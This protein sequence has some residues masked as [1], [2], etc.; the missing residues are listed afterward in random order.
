MALLQPGVVQSSSQQYR[1]MYAP[2]SLFPG[3]AT[4]EK[5]QPQP[6]TDNHSQGQLPVEGNQRA[7]NQHIQGTSVSAHHHTRGSRHEAPGCNRSTGRHHGPPDMQAMFLPGS[8]DRHR[9]GR[10]HNDP[11]FGSPSRRGP[12][13][14]SSTSSLRTSQGINTSG[15]GPIHTTHL[16]SPS[17]QTRD[18]ASHTSGASLRSRGK[19]MSDTACHGQQP[20]PAV[21]AAR[22]GSEVSSE[23]L[24]VNGQSSRGQE[25]CHSPG[26]L[27]KQPSHSRAVLQ[28]MTGQPV[29]SGPLLGCDRQQPFSWAKACA[30]DHLQQHE[31][32]QPM[33]LLFYIEMT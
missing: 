31:T 12:A 28:P 15:G 3:F 20:P 17:R 16:H 4:R 11:H 25:G 2:P 24:L 21:T 5:L 19:D 30:S 23:Q 13:R 10:S 9:E 6:P 7:Q 22:Q 1:H 26:Q 33:C 32:Y 27:G 18:P 29:Q 14:P 8:P